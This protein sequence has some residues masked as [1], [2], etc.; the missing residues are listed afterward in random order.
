M[1]FVIMLGNNGFLLSQSIGML[2][3]VTHDFQLA[4]TQTQI[5]SSSIR[6]D[7]RN[8]Q[9]S[10]AARENIDKIIGECNQSTGT[11]YSDCINA[12]V[13]KIDQ[14]VAEA[15][16]LN[17]GNVLTALAEYKDN[18]KGVILNA[19]AVKTTLLS[20]QKLAGTVLIH[21]IFIAVQVA[22]NMIIEIALLLHS[23][24]APIALAISLIPT[25][26][27]FLVVWL[28]SYV[29]I[30]G[31]QICYTIIIGLAASAIVLSGAQLFSDI[32]F[33]V[34]TA[35]FGPGLAY[36]LS[37]GG[38]VSIYQ[39]INKTINASINLATTTATKVASGGI[40]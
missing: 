21:I 26:K 25:G 14:I 17:D 1:I 24:L 5:A 35:F 4:L 3:A 28:T 27:R 6:D 7:L 33:L 12:A 38:G 9:L 32:A 29:A 36:T 13:P 23:L 22:F 20:P 11:A 37:K 2:R 40:A 8:I 18:I 39:G 10:N 31:V 34:L 15:E 16:A 30:A 19:V